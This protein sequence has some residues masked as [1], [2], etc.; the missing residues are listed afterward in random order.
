MKYKILLIGPSPYKS[1]GGMATVIR[2]IYEDAYLKKYFDVSLLE[3]YYDK[4]IFFTFVNF[5]YKFFKL[6]F[7]YRKY[8]CF[9]IHS[10]S[11]GSFF[12]KMLLINFLVKKDCKV[13]LH[14]HGAYFK[15][16]YE[17][18]KLSQREKFSKIISKCTFVI[19]LSDE[20]KNILMRL[21][22]TNNVIVLYNG[23]D[24]KSYKKGIIIDPKVNY[25]NFIALGRLGERKGTYDIIKA[26]NLIR[27]RDFKI[28]LVGDGDYDK[29]CKIINQLNLSNKIFVY[30]RVEWDD[31]IKLLSNCSTLLLPSYYEG[32]PM[33]IIEG[34]A[35]GKFIISTRVGGIGDLV[36]KENGIL[37][38]AGN[39][40]QL[41]EA[42]SY[43][44]VNNDKLEYFKTN[45]IRKISERF[46]LSVINKKMADIY[47]AA[48]ITKY[49]N[50][51]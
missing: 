25:K 15:D 37:I 35:C 23:V 21:F 26:A 34:M 36:D 3:T 48:I 47:K 12:R 43:V 5:L 50:I 18:L 1:K 11:N 14:I 13:V 31:K 40:A 30:K 41:S 4:N 49:E 8:D 33:S 10:A 29:V 44:L 17:K 16:F 24:V 45:N 6:V 2:Q 7:T 19:A 27:D 32:L 28:Y 38:E 20:W 42:I 46:D 39:I 22:K 9:H 51:N